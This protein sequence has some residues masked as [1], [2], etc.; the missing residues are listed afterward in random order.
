MRSTRG[1]ASVDY[2]ALIA[3]LAVL[4]AAALAFAPAG[5]PGIVNAVAGQIRLALCLVGGGPCPDL[6]SRPCTVA[7]TRDARRFAVSIVLARIDHDRYV[8]REEM[9]DGTV[10]LTTARGG[11]LGVEAGVGGRAKVTVKGRQVGASDEVRGGAQVAGSFGKVFVA[12]DAREAAAFMRAIRD[13]HDPPVSARETVYEGGI[14]GLGTIGVGTSLAGGSLRGLASAMVAA[15]SD[16]GSGDVTLTINA[17]RSGVGAATVAFGGPTGGSDASAILGLTLDRDRRPTELSLSASGTIATGSA[18]PPG[19]ARALGS[20]ATFSA[21]TGGR[22]WELAARLD[23]R[24]PLAAAA[25]A[26]FRDHPASA[27]AIRGLGE[28]LRDR[29]SLDVRTYRADSTSSGGSIG[30]GE[31]VQVGGEFDHTVDRRRLLAARSRPAGGLWEE[32]FDCV[33]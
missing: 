4:V 11:G 6:R 22:H 28:A 13:G 3:V 31:I 9:S 20:A 26:R 18:L 27:G 25:W 8:L 14:R 23:L 15:R 17:G 2:V 1:Q 32:R 29:A 24:D 7:S 12:R 16:H 21:D 19:L 30:A 10:R 33:A 5:A